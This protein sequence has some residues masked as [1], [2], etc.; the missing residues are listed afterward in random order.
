M[1]KLKRATRGRTP[2]SEESRARKPAPQVGTSSLKKGEVS[3]L[4]F[5]HKAASLGFALSLPYGVL[6][7]D[8]VVE[9][10]RNLWRVQVK[11]VTCMREG[12]Y[13]IAIRH[14]AEHRAQA[15]TGSEIDFVAAYII[16]EGTWYILPVREVMGRT[17]FH[18]RPRG[19]ARRDPYARYREAWHLLR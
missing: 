7:Y 16:P 8:F 1:G 2:A 6:P 13:H 18:F 14:R 11:S 4:A 10:G 17:S 3:E 19:W 9:G 12:L 5:L 15:Y